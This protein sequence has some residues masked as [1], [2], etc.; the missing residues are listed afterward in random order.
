MDLAMT[1]WDLLVNPNV[2]YLLLIMGLWGLMTA[3]A[4]PG[5][6][7]P[8]VAAMVCLTLAVL[9]LA[10]LDVS[11]IGVSLIAL[12]MVM[13]VIDL[14]VQS[15]GALTL[16]GIITLALGSIFLFRP[17]EG[18]AGLSGWV[19]A[20]T[21]VGS[22]LFFG[23]ALGAAMRAQ[24][25]PIVMEP[26][27]VAGQLGEVRDPLDPI[28]TVQLRSELWSAKAEMAGETIGTGVKVIVTDLEGLTLKVKRVS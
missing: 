3:F 19:V 15:H 28:G 2:A 14:K 25:R 12:S 5:T 18:Q 21:T 13:L 22:G 9:G 7:V 27:A 4:M 1:F 16:G 11:V 17:A 6:G 8:E 26:K 24:K 20:L 23:V 10:R